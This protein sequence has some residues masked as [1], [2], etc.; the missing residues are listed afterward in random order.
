MSRLSLL[1]TDDFTGGLNLR[2]DPFQL[3]DNES[4]DLLNVDIDP[5]GGF[6][7]RGGMTKLNTSAVGGISN[8]VF[9][10]KRL[11][12]WD[13]STPQVLLSANNFSYY[14]TT[15][16]FS[17][18]LEPSFSITNA[19]YSPTFATTTYTTS[20]PHGYSTGDTVTVSGVTPSSFNRT[21]T[22]TVGSS[23]TFYFSLFNGSTGGAYSSG[24]FAQK[25]VPISAPFGA[26]FASW[27]ASD[28]SLVYIA[29][30]STSYKWN[31]STATS[32]TPSETGQWQNDY[33]A[34]TGTHMPKSRHVS[35][36]VDR[37]WCAYTTESGIDYPNRVRFSH[38]I[39]RE[40]WAEADYIDIVEGGSGITAIVPF[41]GNLLVFKKRAVFAI[42]GYSTDTFQVV[43]LTSEVGAVNAM[44]VAATERAVYFFSWPDGLFMYDGQRFM[45]L[46]TSIRPIIQDG[47]VNPAAQDAICV[48]AVNRK[49]WVSLP[50]A[51][52]TKPSYTFVYDPSISQRG[53]WSKY[54]TSDGKGVGPGCDFITSTGA[55]HYLVCHPSNPY[56]LKADQLFVYQDDVGS[57]LVNFNSYYVT[58]WH[59]ARSVSSRKMWRRPDFITKQTSV[60]T[61]LDVSVYHD[62]EESIVARSFQ[63]FL[64]GSSDALVWSPPGTEPDGIDGWNEANWGEEASGSAFYKGKNVGLARSVQLKIA[65]EGGKPWGVN[66]ITYKFNP[67]KVRA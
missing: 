51:T 12:A 42:L 47:T 65:G 25:N 61:T 52:E 37:L 9:A 54:Q 32:L 31:G 43:S 22:I 50:D 29:T 4:P 16:S 66:S 64:D 6:Q 62:W 59:D 11:F 56:V 57:G 36:H 5:R 53:A 39:N 7:M 60:D 33:S 20:A 49:V 8:G 15:T 48:S 10:P 63:I 28:Q 26:S 2:A 40:S 46:F 14:A 24:G 58:R 44:A 13:N 21:A 55:T 30:G 35:S 34:P 38:P 45:D 19:V 18:M 17:R 27:S 1:R 41:N 3:G 23:T 67:R